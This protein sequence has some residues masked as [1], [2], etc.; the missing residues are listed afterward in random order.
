MQKG[1][2]STFHSCSST[3]SRVVAET[4]VVAQPFSGCSSTFS[5]VVAE[6]LVVADT[7]RRFEDVAQPSAGF[8]GEVQVTG[9]R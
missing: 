3:F 9:V 7:L 8:K 1:C 4:I 5:T 2:S 6:T